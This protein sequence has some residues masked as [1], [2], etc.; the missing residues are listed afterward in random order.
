MLGLDGAGKI[1]ILYNLKLNE[2][3][4]TIPTI[5][6]NVETVKYNN[7]NLTIWDLGGQEKIRKLWRHYF[8][9]VDMLIYV[10]ILVML[11]E[12]KKPKMNFII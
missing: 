10:L 8:D 4:H 5:G 1:T 7:L 6:F 12:L 11:V 3:I 2:F 9:N